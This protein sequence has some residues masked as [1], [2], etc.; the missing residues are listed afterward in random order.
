[1]AEDG[2][3]LAALG[4]VLARLLR[5][6]EEG[7]EGDDL[8]RT[9]TE[10]GLTLPPAVDADA[11]LSSAGRAALQRLQGLEPIIDDLA[12]AVTA[13]DTGAIVTAAVRL[14]DTV[15]RTVDD[16]ATVADEIKSLA[17]TGIPQPELDQFAADLPGRL[18]EYLAVRNL[19]GLPG[20]AQA[21][22]FIGAVE[23]VEMPGVDPAHPAFVKRALHLDQLTSFLS[24]PA[25]VLKAR[26]LWGDP[27]FDGVALLQT[28]SSLLAQAGVPA[29]LD[30]SGPVPVLDVVAV[31]VSPKLDDPK[32]L[33]VTLARGLDVDESAP[34][35]Q[36]DWK[37]VTT[38]DASLDVGMEI[39]LM[40]TDGVTV[41]PVGTNQ[42]QGDLEVEW[43]G[44]T[45]DGP[46]YTILGE[47]GGSRLQAQQ[48]VLRAGVGLAW[49]PTAG[50]GTGT[51]S[52]A[53]E[54]RRG[55]LVVSL[56]QAD[57]FLGSVL[58]GFGLESDFD[59]GVGYSTREGV[60]FAGSATLDI[61]L[62]LHVELGPVELSALTV[63]V[64]LADGAFPVGLRA[65]IKAALGPLAGRDRAGRGRRRP[66]DP[67]R[68][69]RQRRAARLHAALPAA[70]G[71]RPLA[72][73]R[74]GQGRR[75]PL[76]RRRARASTPGRWSWRSSTSSPI[77]A[78]G[79]ITTK[80]PDG[81][82]G[83]SLL[84]IMSV[85][86][87][88]GIQLGFGFT[89]LGRRRAGRPQPHD[90]PAG[91]GRGRPHRRDRVGDV[92]A[93]TSSPTRR[94]SSATCGRSSRREQGTF[95]IGPMVKLGWGT[96]TLVSLSLGVIIEI[97]GNIAIVG[98][99]KV[100]L[101]ADD[102]ALI[103]LQVNFVGA[104]EFDK[105]RIWFFA[106]LFESRIVFLTID[107]EM[108]LLVAFGDD[109]NFV[110]QRR[111]LPPAVL[112]AAAA[113]P[114]PAPDRGQ[115]A[116]HAGVADPRRGLLRGHLQHRPVRRAGRGVLRPRHPQRPGPPRVRRAVPV[117]AVLLHHRDLRVALGEGLRRRPVLG[118]ACA[119]RSRARRPGTSRARLDLA[120]VL[121]HRRRLRGHLGRGRG[122]RAAAD[123]GPAARSAASSTRRRTGGACCRPAPTCWSRCAR[124]PADRGGAGAAPGRRPARLPARA[125][126][127]SIKLDKVGNAASPTTSTGCRSTSPAAAWP[128]RTTRSS[129][130][131]RRS[132]RT[133]RDA[134]KLSQPAFAPEHVG[135]RPVG[136]RRATPA[137]RGMVR[138][139]VRYE[140]IIIDSNYKRF[141]APV[142]SASS[143][144]S[145]TSSSA[146]TRSPKCE[147]SQAHQ[148]RAAAR[149]RTR[150][151]CTPRRYAVALQADNTAFAADAAVF[152]SEASARG[153]P[154][155]AGRGR[156]HPGRPRCT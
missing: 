12:A 116:Q 11:S 6:L 115:P 30:T 103:V 124:M 13:D 37:V 123:R 80:M 66:G 76:H 28:L 113:V 15:A 27:A 8:R 111:R 144:C 2:G 40:P 54:V 99:L 135:P 39:V 127:S 3:T 85:E 72:R 25:A 84:I 18:V 42:A 97:P 143:A 87:G 57:G 14:V 153:V 152:H 32:G 67:R 100:A 48:F 69:V 98:M 93:T 112:A 24:D 81:S 146:A 49:N 148:G 78:I 156:P 120:A 9:L 1:M 63:T 53:G 155:R 102:V 89:L 56:A 65:D 50:Q 19:E 122:H 150:S 62:P 108:G 90:E 104:I 51:F 17:G 58:G 140:E 91:A 82:T 79:I 31:E 10:L 64:G 22:Q 137:R 101:P 70:Q 107:G 43:T 132:S 131:R 75:L 38:L 145:S 134:D 147:L 34:F 73:R 33:R 92:P 151:R 61:Q 138:R 52:V 29:V 88:A 44:G 45:L 23:R 126:R 77:Q 47:P 106:S 5:P 114:E 129:S 36:D 59:L 110:R 141:A 109:A 125:C 86:F 83:F 121:G 94:G 16:V 35:V 41:K 130:S 96:P 26:Y 20:A 154:E 68:H 119:A 142:P 149:S 118:A 74:R 139:V 60:F 7:L 117:L 55:K 4:E 136:G 105:K 71:R 95:L 46:P 133:S 128:R 21:G